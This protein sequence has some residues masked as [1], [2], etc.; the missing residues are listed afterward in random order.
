[1]GLLQDVEKRMGESVTTFLDRNARAGKSIRHCS[2]LMDVSY[3]TANRWA[4]KNGVKFNADN[5]FR[6]WRLK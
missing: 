6:S 4:R 1:M 2:M 3:S 5:P